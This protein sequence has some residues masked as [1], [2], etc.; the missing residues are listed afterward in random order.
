MGVEKTKDGYLEVADFQVGDEVV[1]T[2]LDESSFGKVIGKPFHAFSP[3]NG[4]NM[5]IPIEF[6]DGE[7]KSVWVA[8]VNKLERA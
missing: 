2:Y 3:L 4:G 8:I 5:H 1:V 7:K 6:E